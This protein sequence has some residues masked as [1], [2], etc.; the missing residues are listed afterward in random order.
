MFLEGIRRN[1]CDR[2]DLES[3]EFDRVAKFAGLQIAYGRRMFLGGT[4]RNH[5]DCC[6]LQSNCKGV[7]HRAVKAYGYGCFLGDPG[8]T[9]VYLRSTWHVYK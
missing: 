6:D 9:I 3:W 2:C 4:K 7:I 5:C 8:V 1:H